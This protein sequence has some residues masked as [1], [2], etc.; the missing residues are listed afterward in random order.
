M[1]K[2]MTCELLRKDQYSRIVSA[3]LFLALPG[4]GT[5]HRDHSALEEVLMSLAGGRALHLPKIMVE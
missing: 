5:S 4:W 1:G 3:S 2:T